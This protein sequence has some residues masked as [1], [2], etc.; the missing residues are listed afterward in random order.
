MTMILAITTI[1]QYIQQHEEAKD[2]MTTLA[3]NNTQAS[4]CIQQP[5]EASRYP[6][7]ADR[8]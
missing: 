6:V 3:V 2:N 7:D 5:P 4:D 1:D 8:R